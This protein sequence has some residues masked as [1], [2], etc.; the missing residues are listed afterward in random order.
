MKT[1]SAG[2]RA[3]GIAV[4]LL[5]LVASAAWAA[6][7]ATVDPQTG[8]V[9]VTGLQPGTYTVN[10]AAGAPDATFTVPD[11]PP[12]PAAA[13]VVEAET[14]ALAPTSA[15]VVRDDPT[16]S[17]GRSLL[18]WA[19]G[20]AS[21]TVTAPAATR[22]VV[23]ARGNQCDGAPRMTLTVDGT[24]RPAI[25]VPATA[26]TDYSVDAPLAAGQ[27]TIRVGYVN[28]YRRTGCDRDLIVDTVTFATG[29]APAPSPT[30]EP[31]PTATP[32][33]APTGQPA[34]TLWF[35][36]THLNAWPTKIA[37]RTDSANEVPDPLGGNFPTIRLRLYAGDSNVTSNPR[38]Q[39]ETAHNIS[40]GADFWYSFLLLLP[41]GFPTLSPGWFA[42]HE[43]YGAPYAGSPPW[44]LGGSTLQG[45]F[46]WDG[47]WATPI[48]GLA[49][50]WHR[51]TV[52]ELFSTNGRIQLWLDGTQQADRFMATR[53][54][55]NGGAPNGIYAQLYRQ[56]GPGWPDP[57]DIYEAGWKVG[58]T[59]EIV[60]AP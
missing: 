21:R 2:R 10:D 37:N 52:H 32:T 20:A 42:V 30:P 35:D 7:T 27:H 18:I 1:F 6:A 13:P 34:G 45:V 51:I 36:G 39:L 15:G 22:L 11:P 3:A 40:E 23:R 12:P 38:V 59:R 4:A 24:Q 56:A 55:T 16:A 9:T 58:T 5:L 57:T 28:D 44:A 49:G 60:E 31:T 43:V 8:T 14:M 19:N 54:S 46:G 29:P 41:D 33:P 25:D 47:V 50:R 48:A 53:D 26:L 17:A